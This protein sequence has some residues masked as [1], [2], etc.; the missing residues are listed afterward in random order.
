[1]TLDFGIMF[2]AVGGVLSLM[3]FAPQIIK[4]QKT[5]STKDIAGLTYIIIIV[6]NMF[7]IYYAYTDLHS[8]VYILSSV[9]AII[10]SCV[11]LLLKRR[12]D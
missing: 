3:L 5:K 1:M 10:L 6:Y 9:G 8:Y 12:Y 2:G 4:S 7:S 11:I